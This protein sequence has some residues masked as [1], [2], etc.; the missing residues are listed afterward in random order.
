MADVLRQDNATITNT[1][2]EAIVNGAS[3]K[4]YT[5]LSISLCNTHATNDETFSVFRADDGGSTNKRFIYHT[6]SLPAHSTFIHNDK[7]V[8]ESLQELHVASP[9]ASATIDVV[10]SYLE[11]D[12]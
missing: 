1:T 2:G 7:I 12:D 3:G 9:S 6:Q 5:I 10:I 11:Q 8:L 4:T